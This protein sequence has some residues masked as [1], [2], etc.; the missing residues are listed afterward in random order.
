MSIDFK[1]K[2]FILSAI[3]G[4]VATLLFLI[5]VWL[6]FVPV[7][8]NGQDVNVF[9]DA[10]D[11][12][13]SVYVKIRQSVPSVGSTSLRLGG[14]LNGLNDVVP[15]GCYA[16]D[17][18]IGAFRLM[19]NIAKGRQ[20]PVKITIPIMRTVGEL[21]NRLSS[22][23]MVDSTSLADAIVAQATDTTS[24]QALT[25]FI[26]N[27]YEVYWNISA[28]AFVRRMIKERDAYWAAERSAASQK[29]GLTPNEAY[30][31][32]SIVEQETANDA[33]RPMVAGM[34][35]NR[36]RIGMKLQA[37]PTVKFALYESETDYSAFKIRRVTQKMCA[38]DNPYNTY[39]HAGLPIGPIC[40]PSQASLSAV[41]H[42]AK[43][44]YIYMCAKD[45]FSGTHNFATT[46]AEHLVNAKRYAQ[47]L[48][49][50]GITME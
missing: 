16:I 36:L 30:I 4:V 50:R 35:L 21:A 9:I 12:A 5:L 39:K 46:Y 19:H 26:P 25:L 31:L 42:P 44:D 17:T 6:L 49:E 47:A 27:T 28:D 7:N 43:H 3:V 18:H 15:T 1:S 29:I 2:K 41:L 33:E 22:M 40:I 8:R 14:M 11:T 38:I 23:L 37:D 48:N 32:A 45:D 10:D 13:D 24:Q 34:Y 20:T